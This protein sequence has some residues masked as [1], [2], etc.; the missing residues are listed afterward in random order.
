MGG[1]A[2]LPERP[3]SFLLCKSDFQQDSYLC[4]MIQIISAWQFEAENLGNPLRPSGSLSQHIRIKQPQASFSGVGLR[5]SPGICHICSMA[6][7]MFCALA[8]EAQPFPTLLHGSAILDKTSITRTFFYHP[9]RP[10]IYCQRKYP[11]LKKNSPFKTKKGKPKKQESI[12][13]KKPQRNDSELKNIN[14]LS[15][16]TGCT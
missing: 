3:H 6:W 14:V 10:E 15:Q 13:T 2:T 11:S 5:R 8:S 7:L 9:T 16:C 4:M 1:P 12:L